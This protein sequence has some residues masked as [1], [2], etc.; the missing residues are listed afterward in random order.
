MRLPGPSKSI[1]GADLAAHLARHC[2]KVTVTNL[3]MEHGDV[4][5]T[6]RA[7]AAMVDADLLVMGAYAHSKLSQLVL[8]GVTSYMLAEAEL[9][10]L[11]SY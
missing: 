7:H 3:Q 10:I 6:L 5:K 9:P 8:G 11:L 4:A 2:K 1:E